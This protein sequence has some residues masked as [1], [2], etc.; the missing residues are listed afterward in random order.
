MTT[1]VWAC[2]VDR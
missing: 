1:M 2:K